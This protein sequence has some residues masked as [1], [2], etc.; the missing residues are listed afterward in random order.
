[1]IASPYGTGGV[2]AQAQFAGGVAI[3]GSGT[4]PRPDPPESE[5]VN[6]SIDGDRQGLA[7]AWTNNFCL[8]WTD[9]CSTCSRNEV[10]EDATCHPHDDSACRR[11]SVQCKVV[12][13]AV[14]HLSCS[15]YY[16]GV[17]WC[18]PTFT[19][20]DVSAG[21]CTR[22]AMV[23]GSSGS[24]DSTDFSCTKDWSFEERWFCSPDTPE[25]ARHLCE[26]DRIK[27]AA[28]GRAA[29]PQISFPG[30]RR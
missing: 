24:S 25:A 12:D 21:I 7:S 13:E 22:R 14:L 3:V 28:A 5:Q 10:W 27:K 17:N 20:D 23:P 11:R 18:E 30:L 1:M 19:D 6:P 26:A 16:N 4:D 8:R 29:R 2:H 15:R 9:G